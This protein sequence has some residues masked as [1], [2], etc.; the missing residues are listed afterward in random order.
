MTSLSKDSA[1]GN[2]LPG[3]GP[4]APVDAEQRVSGDTLRVL[5]T[6]LLALYPVLAAVMI[7]LLSLTFMGPGV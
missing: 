6:G 1:L 4:F 7:A 5:L 3:P 2:T